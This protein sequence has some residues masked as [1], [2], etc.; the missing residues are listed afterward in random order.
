[1]YFD[2][3]DANKKA[4]VSQ[5]THMDRQTD[6]SKSRADPTRG[7]SA[8]NQHDNSNI[9][10]YLGNISTSNCSVSG[11]VGSI[12]KYDNLFYCF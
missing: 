2:I 7:G 5:S 3:A 1:M 4:M 11:W 8:K 6:M 10:P 9:M 12:L